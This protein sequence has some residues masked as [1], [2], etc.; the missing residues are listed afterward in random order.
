MSGRGLVRNNNR[1]SRRSSVLEGTWDTCDNNEGTNK[2]LT[3]A[4]TGLSRLLKNSVNSMIQRTKTHYS[5]FPTLNNSKDHT[6]F[7]PLTRKLRSG[8]CRRPHSRPHRRCTG[9]GWEW[10][11]GWGWSAGASR[12]SVFGATVGALAAWAPSRASVWEEPSAQRRGEKRVRVST[13]RP[14]GPERH[15]FLNFNTRGES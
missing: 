8:M 2:R 11:E 4:S 6:T 5:T 7:K 12:D 3:A 15:E 9:S 1:R 14:L 10:A 13:A